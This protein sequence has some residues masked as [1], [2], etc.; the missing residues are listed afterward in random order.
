MNAGL[1]EYSTLE[2][3]SQPQLT[4]GVF[5]QSMEYSTLENESQ[6]QLVWVN[7]NDVSS[8]ALWKMKANRNRNGCVSLLNRSIALWKMKANRNKK[9]DDP[10]KSKSIALWKMK[11]N[12][13]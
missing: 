10:Q 6:P 3:E 2:N 8:I 7:C 13:N 5:R 9:Q 11:A 12:R 1:F 4:S